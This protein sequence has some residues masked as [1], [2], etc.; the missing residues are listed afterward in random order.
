MNPQTTPETAVIFQT[1]N[2]EATVNKY[3]DH[4]TTYSLCHNTE[5]NKYKKLHFRLTN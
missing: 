4:S 5:E 3:P 1:I 2:S